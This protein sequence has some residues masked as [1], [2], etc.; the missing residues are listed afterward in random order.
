M[1]TNPSI[2]SQ[3][4]QYS[5]PQPIAP[6]PAP[7]SEGQR[8]IGTFFAPGRTFADLRR[9]ASWWAPFLII[10]VFSVAFVYTAGQ[11]VGFRKIADN[12]LQ[13]QPKQAE[14]L[15]RMPPADRE[16]NMQ[17]RVAAT[18]YISYGYFLFILVWFVV[19]AAVLL[20]TLKFGLSADVKYKT[21]L[22]LVVYAGLPGV[23]KALL[24]I[25]SLLAGVAS[26]SFTFQNSVA[27]NPG[28]FIDASAHPVLHALLSSFD[29]FAFW[30]MILVAIGITRVS[31]VKTNAAFAVVFGW[32]AV[33]VLIGVGATAAFS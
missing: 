25:A 32:F 1:A 28:Y 11:K 9:N 22:A 31:K 3:P 20:G 21:L 8:L 24:G 27:T 4:P 19:V 29:V 14:Q 13:A 12:Q 16:K 23:L 17:T 18:R 6:E 33:L 30:S 10:A 15:E 26:D 2:P 7:L 5:Q